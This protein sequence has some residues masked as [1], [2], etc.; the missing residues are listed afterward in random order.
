MVISSVASMATRWLG[1]RR[2]DQDAQRQTGDDV[3]QGEKQQHQQAAADGD[4]EPEAGEK[5]DDHPVQQGHDDVGNGLA[6][7]DL[8]RAQRRDEQQG[9]GAGL[10]L[11]GDA[12]RGEHG[13]DHQQDDGDQAGDEEE[14]AAGLG[15][16]IDLGV[17][18]CSSGPLLSGRR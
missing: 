17:D 1:R 3:E 8:A 11:L 5:Q 15:I 6:D 4:A 9:D 10:P 18:A 16:E 7:D 14:L 12:E 2:G 13:R